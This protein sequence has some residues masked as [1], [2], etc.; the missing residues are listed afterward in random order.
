MVSG[1]VHNESKIK[2]MVIS[3]KWTLINFILSIIGSVSGYLLSNFEF[4]FGGRP[5]SLV[6]GRSYAPYIDFVIIS[7]A[8]FVPVV[9]GAECM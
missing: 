1:E 9:I 8:T 6:L 7:L 4:G 2:T 5:F 3:S